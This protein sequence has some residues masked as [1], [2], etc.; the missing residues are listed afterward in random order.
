ML[1]LTRRCCNA[2]V[3]E[4]CPALA[5]VT[6]LV[7]GGEAV[8][9][10]SGPQRLRRWPTSS[11]DQSSMARPKTTICSARHYRLDQRSTH[12]IV[13]IG[14]PI[15]N[16]RVYV[17][18][19][20]LGACAGGGCGGALH[21]G[22]GA[23][24]GLSGP[25]RADGGAVC[26]GPVWACGE[27]DVPDRG[28]GALARGRGAGVSRARR[29]AGEAAR[30]P[31]RAW[32][33]RG[34]AGA[35]SCCGAGGGDCARGSARATSGWWPMWWRRPDRAVGCGGAAG[36]CLG[37]SLPD[38]MVPSAF[39]V[40]ERLPL[41]PERQA[42][43]PGA[44]GAGS[45][46]DACGAAPRTPQEEILCALF[47]EVLGLERVGIDDNFFE[48][49]GHSLLATRL[50]SRIRAT[51]D[52]EVAIRGAVRSADRG[53][54]GQAAGRGRGGAAGACWRC[55]ARPR[56]R[57]RLRSA[58]CGSSIGWKGRARPTR[59]RWRCG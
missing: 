32:R 18:D 42:R 56:F 45:D 14:R 2:L 38:Y 22:S 40:L 46:A 36:A 24:A 50:I 52:V 44:A 48:L 26:G 29:R 23:G 19:G 57:C 41:T 17:L 5:G 20:G 53:G 3:P 35:P 55:R 9:P 28:S 30:L 31:D 33:D 16:T 7:A 12:A 59:S 1:H 4:D 13:P 51:L 54:A 47:A 43:P 39:V 11:T 34:G 21:C 15:W 25:C 10:I 27:P 6:Q 8:S 58:G 49:G 37:A